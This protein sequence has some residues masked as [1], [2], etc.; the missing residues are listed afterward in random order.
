VEIAPDQEDESN[1]LL[2]QQP[3]FE[4]ELADSPVHAHDDTSLEQ[5]AKST[6]NT[7]LDDQSDIA[8][9]SDV[10]DTSGIDN[11]QL[12]EPHLDGNSANIQHAEDAI[13]GAVESA[14]ETGKVEDGTTSCN[15]ETTQ[16]CGDDVIPTQ[17]RNNS[18]NENVS[19]RL[20]TFI[21][22]QSSVLRL[23]FS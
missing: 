4:H 17:E 8:S 14:D 2:T 6:E 23:C 12:S 15:D 18:V 5:N 20:R 13:V 3:D 21:Q 19:Y 11:S 1:A 22:V 16:S 10:K 7:H 9:G